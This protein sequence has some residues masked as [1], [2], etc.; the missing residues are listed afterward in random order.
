MRS[1]IVVARSV[2]INGHKTSVSLEKPFWE[3]CR[4]IAVGRGMTLDELLSLI[5]AERAHAN[6]ASAIRL[7]VLA[8]VRSNAAKTIRRER[9]PRH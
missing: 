5:D 2:I 4:R 3:E 8:D 9:G 1:G 7:Y 6:L